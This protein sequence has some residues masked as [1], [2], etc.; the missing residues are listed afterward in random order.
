MAKTDHGFT[1]LSKCKTLVGIGVFLIIYGLEI[2]KNKN[3]IL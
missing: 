3:E 1:N 2:D